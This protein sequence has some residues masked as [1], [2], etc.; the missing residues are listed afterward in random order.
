MPIFSEIMRAVGLKRDRQLQAS[1]AVSV[2]VQ[3]LPP[4]RD[5][6]LGLPNDDFPVV[7]IIGRAGTGKSTRVREMMTLTGC[8]QVVLAPTGVAALNV[9]GQTIH[10]FF[11]LPPRIINPEDIRP[12]PG[13]RLLYQK[14]ERVIIDEM[15]MVRAD[16]LDAIDH[17]LRINRGNEAPFGGV[18]IVLIG[19]FLQLPP[20]VTSEEEEILAHRGYKTSCVVGAHVL[21]ELRFKSREL[22]TVHRQDD[23]RFIRMLADLRVGNNVENVVNALNA[24]CYAPHR[25]SVTPIVLTATNARADSHNQAK[26][27]A[28]PGPVATYKGIIHRAFPEKDFPAPVHLQLKKEARVILVKNDPRRRW[29][30]GSLATV[31]RTEANSVWVR[32]DGRSDECEVAREKWDKVKYLWSQTENRIITEIV[33]SYSQLPLKAAWAITIYR[34]QGLTF[35]D[36]RVDL[37]TGTFASGQA[38]VALSRVRSLAGLSLAHPLAAADVRVDPDLLAATEEIARRASAWADH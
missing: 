35:E 38:Y 7:M 13:R 1:Q 34:S 31:T 37:Q 11:G 18:K 27:A 21:Q 17:S 26:L 25:R 12:S 36:V 15:S 8:N 10:S 9:G 23:P 29:V 32:L 24:E 14:L 19:D 30:N 5:L 28:L 3:R 22:C 6:A 33:G 4:Q 2:A 20:I 16:L